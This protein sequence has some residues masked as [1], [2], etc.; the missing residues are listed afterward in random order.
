MIY[1]YGMI[2]R[3]NKLKHETGTAVV[4]GTALGCLETASGENVKPLFPLCDGKTVLEK[5][6]VAFKEST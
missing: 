6:W 2:S 4:M 1:S 3:K 5:S